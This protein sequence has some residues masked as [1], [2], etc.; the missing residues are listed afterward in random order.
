MLLCDLAVTNA[1]G[2]IC[3][4]LFF[5]LLCGT[6]V[7]LPPLL[8]MELTKDKSRLGA[9]MGMAYGAMGLSVL[10]GGPGAG[11]V[12]EHGSD[13]SLD[14]MASWTYAGVLLFSGLLVFCVLRLVLAGPKV[15][16]RV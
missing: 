12:L 9:R 7:S 8:F 11:G 3:I 14:W 4:A 2:I 15:R 5:G 13:G 6:F 16:V 1:A 10:L